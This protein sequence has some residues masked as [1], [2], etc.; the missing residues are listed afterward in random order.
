MPGVE[1]VALAGWPLLGGNRWRGDVRAAGKPPHPEPAYF[2]TV[3]PGFFATMQMPLLGGRDLRAGERRPDVDAQSPSAGRRRRRQRGV[4]PRLLRRPV[5][6]RRAGQRRRC[7]RT[8]ARR[9]RSSA[10]SAT[11]STPTLRDPLRPTVYLPARQA[12]QRDAARPHRRRPGG[13]RA[14]CCGARWPG[15]A[16]RAHPADRDAA[17]AR[18]AAAD[19]R[20]AAGE[21]VGVRGGRGAAAVGDRPLWR[22]AP[23]RRPAAAADRH[24]HGARRPRRPGRPPRHRRRC[25]PPSPSGAGVGLGG[26]LFFGRLLEGLLFRV[27]TTDATSLLRPVGG[28][29]GGGRRRRPAACP[30]RRAYRSGPDAAIRMTPA[31]RRGSTAAQ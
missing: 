21:A 19:A 29:R 16:R 9:W 18:A 22:A 2:L 12:R 31:S 3:S 20:A 25:L 11:R 26:G 5:A 14:D 4:R 15:P 10:W 17:G 1:S 13:L 6:G 28:A 23:R 7:G 8:S 30:A 24:P 27:S